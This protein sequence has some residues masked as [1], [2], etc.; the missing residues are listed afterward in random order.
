MSDAF[1]MRRMGADE[2]Q[3]AIDWAARE[4]WNPGLHDAHCFY[5]ADPQGFFVGLLN[6]EPI[7]VGSAVVY[8]DHFAFCGLYVVKPEFRGHGYGLQL[9]LS[10]LNYVGS[11]VTGIDGVLNNVSKYEKIGYVAAHKNTTYLCCPSISAASSSSIVD[12]NQLSLEN[13]EKF[14]RRFFPAP[15][16]NFLRAWIAQPES[17][18]LGYLEGGVLLGYGVIRKSVKGYKI[19]PLFAESPKIARALFEALCSLLEGEAVFLCV[20]EPNAD[21]FALVKEYQMTPQFEVMRMYRNG[22]PQL[23]LQGIYGF[24]SYEL[25]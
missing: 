10:R 2:V 1:I 17:R 5:Q 18:A 12:L 14:E 7:A 13:I 24:T 11:R 9:T 8:D 23:D 3:M 21:A 15:R 4:G 6:G 25:G 20:P 22:T 16:S 19:G